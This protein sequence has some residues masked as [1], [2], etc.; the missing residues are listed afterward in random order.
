MNICNNGTSKT[1]PDLNPTAPQGPQIYSLNKNEIEAY[2]PEEIEVCERLAKVMKQFN[3]ITRVT[4]IGQQLL[5][6]G[7]PSPHLQV[8]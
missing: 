1:Y 7:F 6:E 3:T 5:L 2:S 8:C 4:N